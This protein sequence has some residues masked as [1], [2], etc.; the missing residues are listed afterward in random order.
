MYLKPAPGAQV[1]DPQRGDVLP[2]EGRDVEPTQYWQRRINDGDVT[3]A[4][5]DAPP[6]TPPTVSKP[7]KES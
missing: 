4:V 7:K 3:S 6:A 5:A 1:P 2:P